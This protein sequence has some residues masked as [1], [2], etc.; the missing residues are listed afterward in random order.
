MHGAYT[1][2]VTEDFMHFQ[3]VDVDFPAGL[4]HCSILKADVPEKH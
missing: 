4:R 1:C 2:S 3:K